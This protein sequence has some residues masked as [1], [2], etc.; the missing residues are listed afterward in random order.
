MSTT[1]KRMSVASFSMGMIICSAI[2]SS[3]ICYH[4]FAWN[5][6]RLVVTARHSLQVIL[7]D[8]LT[9]FPEIL[10]QRFFDALEQGLIG[11]AAIR[12]EWGDP[13]EHTQEDDA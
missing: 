12:P 11:D 2:T 3:L 1:F 4:D 8:P 9:A 7:H 5:F 6:D 13:K 10:P